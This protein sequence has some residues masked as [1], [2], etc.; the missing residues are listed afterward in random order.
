MH[1][2]FFLLLLVHFPLSAQTLDKPPQDVDVALRARIAKFYDLHVAQKYRQAE[3]LIAEESKDDFY[4]LSKPEIKS[5]RIGDIQYSDKFTRAKVIIIATMPAMLPM[6]GAKLMD[7]PFASYWKIEN[8]IWCWYYNKDAA[9]HTPFGDVKLQGDSKPGPAPTSLPAA[10]DPAALVA[11]L[12]SALKIDRTRVELVPGKPQSIKVT[13]TLPGPASLSVACP[14]KPL[15][16]TGITATF[17]KDNL[18]GNDTAVLTFSVDSS[19]PPG[20]VPI[21]ITVSPTN[22]ILNLMVRITRE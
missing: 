13:N 3:Q 14:L 17:D 6:A 12:Q 7:F 8:G 22:Q 18:K 5:Y 11:S 2:L 1:R 15:A 19:T 21:Q 10:P 20:V 16:E 4:V 9:R